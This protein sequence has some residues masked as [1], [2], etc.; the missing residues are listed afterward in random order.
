MSS[1][2]VTLLAAEPSAST[3]GSILVS[4]MQRMPSTQTQVRAAH[5]NP[6]TGTGLFNGFTKGVL[7]FLP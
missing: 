7:S 1:H 5:N 6:D 4:N 2:G 3:P